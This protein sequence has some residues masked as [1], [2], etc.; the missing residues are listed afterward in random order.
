MNNFIEIPLATHQLARLQEQL[1]ALFPERK[2]PK[3]D[4]VYIDFN[5]KE[6]KITNFWP[7]TSTMGF[8]RAIAIAKLETESY[9]TKEVMA[10]P[11]KDNKAWWVLVRF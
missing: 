10:I 8:D 1:E 4:Y 6:Y 9:K 3:K 7:D 2:W 5:N 11:S